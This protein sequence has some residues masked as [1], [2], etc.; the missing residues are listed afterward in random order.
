MRKI[1]ILLLVLAGGPRVRSLWALPGVAAFA[2]PWYVRNWLVAGS[3]I[4][5]AALQ[6]G[7]LTLARG[8]FTRHAML[9]TVFH[10]NDPRLLPAIVAH[11]FGPT[12]VLLWAPLVLVGVVSM[13]ARW[14]PHGFL[15]AVPLLM[16]PLYWF[17]LGDSVTLVPSLSLADSPVYSHGNRKLM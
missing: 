12:L 11:A 15:A 7:G 6:I 9:N 5:P 1:I 17:G 4:Y 8:A 16:A 10:T 2:L 13:A 14:W 3:P